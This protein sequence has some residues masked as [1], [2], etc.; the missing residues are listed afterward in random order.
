MRQVENEGMS[1]RG[2]LICGY[3]EGKPVN[4]MTIGQKLQLNM[5]DLVYYA[6]SRIHSFS[7]S[8]FLVNF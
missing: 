2:I 6:W 8:K 3:Y 5:K 1:L 4:F 7:I